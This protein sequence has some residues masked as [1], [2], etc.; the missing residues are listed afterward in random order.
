M[1]VNHKN[2]NRSDNRVENL[3]IV[4]AA[5]NNLHA[6]RTLNRSRPSGSKHPAA[7]LTENDVLDIRWLYGMGVRQ[8]VLAKEYELDRTTIRD[9]VHRH[10]W[11]HI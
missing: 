7:K 3:E 1:Q 10:H 5:E 9:L 6:Y 4:T 2:G 11:N 8:F